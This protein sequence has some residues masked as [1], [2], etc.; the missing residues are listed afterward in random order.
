MTTTLLNTDQQDFLW[1][2][3]GDE[4]D[5]ELIDLSGFVY[6]EGRG[7]N[8]LFDQST[9]LDEGDEEDEDN[10]AFVLG[11]Q[12][13]DL[14]TSSVGQD[15]IDGGEG[16]DLIDGKDGNDQLIGSS[17]K[18]RIFGR[19]GR[20]LLDGGPGHDF[21]IGGKSTDYLIGGSG[22][23]V[24]K[25][26]AG[27]DLLQGGD[28]NDSL[29]AGSGDDFVDGGAGKDTLIGGKGDDVFVISLGRSVVKD[30]ALGELIQ[31]DE[32]TVGSNYS[33]RQSGEDLV[34]R[35]SNSTASIT[36]LQTSKSDFDSNEWLQPIRVDDE[37]IELVSE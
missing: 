7:G 33:L 26:G 16:D 22:K 34:I 6:F 32:E 31:Y 10:R 13:D 8:D 11:G 25:A 3:V 37:G 12:G 28:G 35:M 5:N 9:A 1:I 15:T 23:D 14:L 24:L 19:N 2:F 27:N 29:D 18:D 17:G 4:G 36:L 30:Y 20:D 21:L